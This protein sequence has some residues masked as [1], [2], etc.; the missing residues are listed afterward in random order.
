MKN[1]IIAALGSY[2]YYGFCE[3]RNIIIPFIAFALFLVTI[4]EIEQDI[5]D[6]NKKRKG[7]K[8]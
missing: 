3:V 4:E 5:A 1:I 8:V 6:Y 7:R 2:I